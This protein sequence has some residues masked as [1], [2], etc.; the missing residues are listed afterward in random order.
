MR[1]ARR[2]AGGASQRSK[3]PDRSSAGLQ[4]AEVLGGYAGRDDAV[5][6][7]LPRGGVPVAAQVARRLGLDLDVLVTAKMGAPGQEELAL[8][9]VGPGGVS[10]ANDELR[11]ALRLPARA[12]DALADEARAEVERREREYRGAQAPPPRV[13][14]R[15]AILVDDGLATGA[16]MRAA[17]AAV[18][19]MGAARVVVAVPVG[20]R[21]SCD[22]LR[23]E[24]DEVHCLAVPSLLRA[25]GEHYDD[26]EQVSDEEVRQLLCH[27]GDGGD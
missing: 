22:A 17:V 16:S 20:A 3:F 19:R 4:L 26:F 9:A 6:L 18:R 14:G 10:V 7:A 2:D 8:G 11:K 23:R 1:D 15:T 27:D 5:V 25:V 12:L 13:E 21:D 24:A